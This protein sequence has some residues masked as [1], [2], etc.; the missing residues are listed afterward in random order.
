MG[1][2]PGNLSRD[3]RR[4]TLPVRQNFSVFARRNLSQPPEYQ[5]EIALI[6]EPN[7][8]ANFGDRLEPWQLENDSDRYQKNTRLLA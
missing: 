5:P 2:Q 6:A 1:S 3:K 4:R 8:P 7:V